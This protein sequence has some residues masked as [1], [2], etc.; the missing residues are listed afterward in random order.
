M[1]ITFS[2][3]QD[4][5]SN[6]IKE[7][8]DWILTNQIGFTTIVKDNVFKINS[9]FFE[10]SLQKDFVLNETFSILIGVEKLIVKSNY[11]NPDLESNVYFQNN[12]INLPLGIRFYHN[13]YQK[14]S[15]YGDLSTYFSYHYLSKTDSEN[16]NTSD[17]EKNIGYNLG[18]QYSFG[19]KY[20]LDEKISC[21][22]GLK[23]KSDLL[24]QIDS[25]NQFKLI[26][27]YAIQIGLGFNL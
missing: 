9:T 11:Y 20:Q 22:L 23:S 6:I 15:L 2:Y 14:I 17:K 5:K 26:N 13:R 12:Y 8:G 24:N 21:Y 4:E 3:S 10:G 1:K 27:F 19:L 7:N 18:F 16:N 25:K